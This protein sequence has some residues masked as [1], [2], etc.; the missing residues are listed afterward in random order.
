MSGLKIQLTGWQAIVVVVVLVGVVAVRFMTLSDMR[1]DKDLVKHIDI[2]LMDEY[3]PHVAGKLRAAYD[4]GDKTEIEK[5]V[6]SVTSTKV[7]IVSVQ[8]SYP[9]LDFSTP[10]D[11]VIKVVFSLDDAN[12][13]GEKRTIYYLFRHG[14][15][16]WQYQYITTSLSYYLNFT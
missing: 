8:A 11:V 15:V 13:T 3:S 12:E 1:N 7:N 5:S 10:K 2:L 14:V 16:G 4:T 9:V 6:K